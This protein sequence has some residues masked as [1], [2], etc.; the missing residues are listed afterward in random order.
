MRRRGTQGPECSSLGPVALGNF[1]SLPGIGF[2]VSR[3]GRLTLAELSIQSGSARAGP[4]GRPGGSRGPEGQNGHTG[5]GGPCACPRTVKAAQAP[6]VT[7]PGRAQGTF[8]AVGGRRTR[9][10]LPNTHFPGTLSSEQG[11][12]FFQ[13]CK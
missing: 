11:S 4:R 1:G 12:T 3:M 10:E 13:G 5:P 2:F 6:F 9:T 7:G 8:S